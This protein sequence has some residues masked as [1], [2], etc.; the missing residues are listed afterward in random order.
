M[1]DN[2]NF[3]F[4]YMPF[5]NSDSKSWCCCSTCK[6]NKHWCSDVTGINQRT[7]LRWNI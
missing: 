5:I 1:Y 7:H 4:T 3:Y 2:D 6:S